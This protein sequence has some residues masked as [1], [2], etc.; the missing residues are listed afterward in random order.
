[1][2]LEKQMT[3]P[4]FHAETRPELIVFDLDG[5]LVDSRRDI[6]AAVDHALAAV[7]APQVGLGAIEPL[8]GRPLSAIFAQLLPRSAA[9]LNERAS[10]AYRDHF[11]ARGSRQ[12]L[13]FPGVLDCL[14]ALSPIPLAIATTK[15]TFM[16]VQVAQEMGLTRHFSLVQGSD[17]IPHKPDPMV[18]HQVLDRLKARPAQSWM[19]GDTVYDIRAGRAAGMRTCAVTHGIGRPDDLA[20]EAPD[21]LLDSLAPLPGLLLSS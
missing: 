9:H 12:S 21:L 2:P 15:M 10:Q 18:L 13:L 17:G 11:S 5:T 6:A 1:L 16:A 3:D 19:I 14:D 8:I 7:G 4:D 20:A